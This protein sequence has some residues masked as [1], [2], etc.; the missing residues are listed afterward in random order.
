MT[1]RLIRLVPTG[2]VICGVPTVEPLPVHPLTD[3]QIDRMWDEPFLSVPQLLARRTIVRLVEKAHG[4][5]R[6]LDS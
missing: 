6:S 5:G 2:E 3:E 4:I 1:A